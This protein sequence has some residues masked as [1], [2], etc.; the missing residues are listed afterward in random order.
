MKI[1]ILGCHFH[2]FIH[3]DCHCSNSNYEYIKKSDNLKFIMVGIIL[4]ITVFYLKDL[5]LALGQTDRIPL[6]LSVWS[7]VIALRLFH[8][9]GITNK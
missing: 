8:L 3:D 6:I 4:C 7:P 9:W 5:S 2:F 1:Y